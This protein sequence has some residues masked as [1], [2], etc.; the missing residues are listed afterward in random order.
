[1]KTL[2]ELSK[3]LLANGVTEY[4][5]GY[6]QQPD[7]KRLRPFVARNESEAEKLVFSEYAVNNLSVYLT[8]I[9]FPENKK[10]GIVVKGC[11]ARS[12]VSLIQENQIARDKV[13][14]IGVECTGV[15][16]DTRLTDGP[17][18]LA[19]KCLRCEVKTPPLYD[20][21]VSVSV[22]HEL[23]RDESKAA[24][25]ER[26]Q[27]MSANDR[28]TFWAAEFEKCI[29]C[30]ACRQACPNCYCEQ[31][32]VDKTTPRWIESS[33]SIRANFAWNIT[34]AFHQAG[35]CTGCGECDRA[36]PVDIP[37][38]LLNMKLGMIAMK[39]YGYKAGMNPEEPTLIG[40]YNINDREDFIK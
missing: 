10:A 14:I 6:T 26:L 27:Q 4:I 11:D 24:L 23:Q 16:S 2:V 31:C 38:S 1:M 7:G 21:L 32:V 29:R 15:R 19:S 33:A 13:Y 18:F 37:L 36:C 3:E 28:F 30:Y 20:E 17:G 8:R 34:R 22:Q 40:T 5:I 12:I 9:P 39:E 35:R 25:M